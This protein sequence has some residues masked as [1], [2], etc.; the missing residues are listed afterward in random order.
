MAKIRRFLG[1][2]AIC[3]VSILLTAW[4]VGLLGKSADTSE[5]AT[6]VE[7][8]SCR[9]Q[10]ESLWLEKAKRKL[11]FEAVIE[12]VK[13]SKD[14]KEAF[15]LL[16]EFYLSDFDNLMNEFFPSARSI[17]LNVFTLMDAKQIS[18]AFLA[19]IKLLDG[20]AW[21]YLK[22]DRSKFSKYSLDCLLK[23]F[24]IYEDFL[25]HAYV[26]ADDGCL[27]KKPENETEEDKK[28]KT[29]SLKM[30]WKR[31]LKVDTYLRLVSI[32]LDFL[33]VKMYSCA[34][35]RNLTYNDKTQFQSFKA[36]IENSLPELNGSKYERYYKSKLK[37]ALD[38]SETLSESI[39]SSVDTVG[40]F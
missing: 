18:D 36:K 15:K 12:S 3:L 16:N 7:N 37:M 1:L 34:L 40:S 13:H 30:F 29:C 6:A 38:F 10:D 4:S 9:G 33:F 20:K 39:T 25:K 2:G 28:R 17:C 35:G 5:G 23:E 31:T 21:F 32:R 8:V 11:Y 27:V 19:A 22:N 24:E 14:S 26:Y